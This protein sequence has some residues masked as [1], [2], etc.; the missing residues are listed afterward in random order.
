VIRKLYKHS[1][2]CRPLVKFVKSASEKNDSSLG[3]TCNY[4]AQELEKNQ[5]RSLWAKDIQYV[6]F[7]CSCGKENHI[8][9]EFSG[10]DPRQFFQ[11]KV[12]KFETRR[13]VREGETN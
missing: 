4:C 11:K 9:V 7:D 12:E 10:F 5:A 3:P 8:R 1:P 6:V 2:F 13:D